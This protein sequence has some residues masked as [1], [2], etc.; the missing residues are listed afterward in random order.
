MVRRHVSSTQTACPNWLEATLT[1]RFSDVLAGETRRPTRAA[2]HV[3]RVSLAEGTAR[4]TVSA[5]QLAMQRPS[6]HGVSGIPSVRRAS[7]T[8]QLRHA[9]RPEGAVEVRWAVSMADEGVA[10]EGA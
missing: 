8:P 9:Q 5:T 2:L 3:G 1:M 7:A 10:I 6:V 4:L